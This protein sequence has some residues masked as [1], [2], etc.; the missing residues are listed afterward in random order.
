MSCSAASPSARGIAWCAF[1]DGLWSPTSAIRTVII[2]PSK[3]AS[4]VCLSFSKQPCEHQGEYQERHDER[5]QKIDVNERRLDGN[6]GGCAGESRLRTCAMLG[7]DHRRRHSY[8]EA[9]ACRDHRADYR[10]HTSRHWAS[11]PAGRVGRRCLPA[12]IEKFEAGGTLRG[13]E[14]PH[15]L[16][17][18]RIRQFQRR[19][20]HKRLPYVD[21]GRT[22]PLAAPIEFVLESCS[23]GASWHGLNALILRDHFYKRQVGSIPDGQTC[24]PSVRRFFGHQSQDLIAAVLIEEQM[25]TCG[26]PCSSIATDFQ[27]PGLIAGIVEERNAGRFVVGGSRSGLAIHH[28]IGRPIAIRDDELHRAVSFDNVDAFDVDFGEPLLWWRLRKDG[29]RRACCHRHENQRERGTEPLPESD[30]FVDHDA[31]LPGGGDYFN[32]TTYWRSAPAI[33]SSL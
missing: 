1:T 8:E 11:S 16:A 3:S 4:T 9:G 15:A 29:V 5:R 25:A 6:A 21:P 30:A 26:R 28:L 23:L 22:E 31:V 10:L 7:N 12:L 27:A 14:Q 33:P 17:P 32:S 2:L 20:L 13:H 19:V 18:L 24:C